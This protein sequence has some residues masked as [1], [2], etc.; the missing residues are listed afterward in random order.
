MRKYDRVDDFY[1][2]ECDNDYKGCGTEIWKI[3]N[4]ELCTECALNE[5]F[6][7]DRAEKFLFQ[8]KKSLWSDIDNLKNILTYVLT[9]QEIYDALMKAY[10]DKKDGIVGH[11]ECANGL[12]ECIKE[13][14][15]ERYF[16]EFF[17]YEMIQEEY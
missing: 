10:K 1:Y 6:T 11:L 4:K 13:N 8:P 2:H 9:E 3:D 15:D 7:L 5:V 12:E 17:G 16:L 14:A